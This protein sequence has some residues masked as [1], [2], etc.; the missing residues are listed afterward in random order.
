[1]CLL[2]CPLSRDHR[3]GSGTD[4]LK[5]TEINNLRCRQSHIRISTR[6]C[7]NEDKPNTYQYVERAVQYTIYIF[8]QIE[9]FETL[10]LSFGFSKHIREVFLVL[11]ITVDICDWNEKRWKTK[12]QQTSP[13]RSNLLPASAAT[14]CG[15]NAFQVRS[16]YTFPVHLN[17]AWLSIFLELEWITHINLR[18][19]MCIGN[20]G[21]NGTHAIAQ[22]PV[23]A[24]CPVRWYVV[25]FRWH[26]MACCRE[27]P[28]SE[29]QN[30]KKPATSETEKKSR[31][32]VAS[33]KPF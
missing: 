12:Y 4:Q 20:L 22:H 27:S 15:T 18:T 33:H 24:F 8:T 21:W 9:G 23:Q 6:A 10:S 26:A 14:F 25:G 7:E 19:T 28:V 16:W 11:F 32:V 30:L 5:R 29:A 31:S 13:N 1:M 17:M 3:Q 2:L